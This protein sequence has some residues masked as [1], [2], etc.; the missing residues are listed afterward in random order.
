MEFALRGCWANNAGF[1]N[2]FSDFC[3]G[4]S[5]SSWSFSGGVSFIGTGGVTYTYKRNEQTRCH[6]DRRELVERLDRDCESDHRLSMA[7][8]APRCANTAAWG[9]F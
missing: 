7:E 2:E 9:S 4:L 1:S 6:E 5:N 8:H 3:N